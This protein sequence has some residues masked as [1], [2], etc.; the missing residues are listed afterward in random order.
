MYVD[1]PM[2]V[3]TLRVYRQAI[4][5]RWPEIRDDVGDVDVFDHGRLV[6]ART[7]RESKAIDGERARCV[8]VS[9][10][11]MATGGRVLHHLAHRLPDPN[12]TVLLVGFQAVSTRG[13]LLQDGATALKML[14][15]Y[16][17]V[18]A[19]V[20]HIPAFSV[21]AG[22]DELVGWLGTCPSPPRTTFV[23]HGEDSGA[24]G[25][26]DRIERELGWTAVVPAYRE[27]VS[28]ERTAP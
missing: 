9:A 3:A 22:A 12:N 4:A 16:V 18:R 21:H 15:R 19:E 27:R 8:I 7:V 6:E 28:L 23:V 5:D 26:R 25:L 24:Q 20:V 10:S 2:A 11:G 13:R 14:G 17:P 1:S